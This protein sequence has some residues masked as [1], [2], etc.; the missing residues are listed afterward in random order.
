[1]LKQID[2]VI[3]MCFTVLMDFFIPCISFSE[4]QMGSFDSICTLSEKTFLKMVKFPFNSQQCTKWINALSLP[5]YWNSFVSV[6]VSSLC[7]N[8]SLIDSGNDYVFK[9]NSK[10]SFLGDFATKQSL[11]IC[12]FLGQGQGTVMLEYTPKASTVYSVFH[13]NSQ[14]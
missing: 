4:N 14:T 7:K 2:D 5:L 8:P 11:S 1:M 9:H 10:T 3:E 13:I 6:S 12:Q